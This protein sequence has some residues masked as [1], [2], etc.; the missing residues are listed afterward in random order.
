MAVNVFPEDYDLISFFEVEP[1]VLDTDVPW[2]YNTI[3]FQ[4]QYADELLYCTFSPAY[5]D[6]DLTLVSNQKSKTY[7]QPT[8][9]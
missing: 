4:K 3:T 1:E 2:F 5:G 6:L 8:Q 7:S 9:H